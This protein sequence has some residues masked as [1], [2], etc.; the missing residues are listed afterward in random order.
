MPPFRH[1]RETEWDYPATRD[2]RGVLLGTVRP[3]D[4]LDLPEAPD[5]FWLPCEDAGAAGSAAASEAV[6]APAGPQPAPPAAPA[7]QT[8]EAGASGS[9]E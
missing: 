8:S 5:R 9:E 7:T 6:T 4:V 1:T 2:S 3:G